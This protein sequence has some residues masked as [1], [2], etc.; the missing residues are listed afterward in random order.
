MP[1]NRAKGG[2]FKEAPTPNIVPAKFSITGAQGFLHALAEASARHPLARTMTG[3]DLT[4]SEEGG[5]YLS[6]TPAGSPDELAAQIDRLRE[7]FEVHEGR[8]PSDR[9]DAFWEAVNALYDAY[10]GPELGS[11]PDVMGGLS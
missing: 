7:A 11:V 6:V 10:D 8:P 3:D 4:Y 5:S 2:L 9:D 1:R